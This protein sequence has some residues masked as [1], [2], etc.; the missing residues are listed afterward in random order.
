MDP[1]MVS[2]ASVRSTIGAL[3]GVYADP[4]HMVGG[5]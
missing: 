4:E 5:R 3:G 1:S 2:A